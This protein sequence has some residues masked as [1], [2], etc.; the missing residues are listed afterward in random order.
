MKFTAHYSFILF[1][2]TVSV[3]TRLGAQEAHTHGL[4]TLTLALENGILEIEFESPATNLVG[5]EHQAKSPEQRKAVTQTET[6][7]KDP[8]LLFS[9]VGANCQPKKTTVDVSGVM[10]DEHE[11]HEHKEHE[12]EEHEHEEHK[13]HGHSE[14][15]DESSHSEISASYR[16]S[17]KDAKKLDSVS[18]A[19]L[20]QFPGIEKINAMWVTETKQGA[21]SLTSN[22]S[23]ILL[24]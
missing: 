7:L 8:K 15:H 20:K 9:F 11:E 23:T 2:L 21:V 16:F 17:C 10:G 3:M 4:A 22:S 14:G 5:F 19:L 6:T 12:H 13:N 24:R 1:L 18:V